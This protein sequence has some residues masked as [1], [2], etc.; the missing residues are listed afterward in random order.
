METIVESFFDTYSDDFF[1]Y[2]DQHLVLKVMKKE[3]YKEKNSQ[4]SN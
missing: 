2:F 1:E 4:I 3:E